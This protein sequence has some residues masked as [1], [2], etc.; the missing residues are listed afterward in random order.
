[1]VTYRVDDGITHPRDLTD[2]EAR[3]VYIRTDPRLRSGT[4]EDGFLVY[5]VGDFDEVVAPVTRYRPMKGE[6]S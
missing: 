5:A 2:A 3:E 6:Q 4:Y 1:M